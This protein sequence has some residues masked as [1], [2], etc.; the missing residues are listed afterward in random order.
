MEKEII[1]IPVAPVFYHHPQALPLGKAFK[2]HSYYNYWDCSL[3]NI[4]IV[5]NVEK[6]CYIG[7]EDKLSIC[8]STENKQAIFT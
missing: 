2:Y 7:L 4:I 8:T 1:H 6:R 5:Y 3:I